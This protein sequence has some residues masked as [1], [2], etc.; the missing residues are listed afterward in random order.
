MGDYRAL[1]DC[2]DQRLVCSNGEMGG[3]L[4]AHHTLHTRSG[5]RRAVGRP[6]RNALSVLL[7]RLRTSARSVPALR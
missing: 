5:Q 2:H 6:A 7:R 3:R 4:L 1:K